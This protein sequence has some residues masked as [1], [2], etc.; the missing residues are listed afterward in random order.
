VDEKLDMS[1]QC[2]LTTQIA[3][4]TLGCIKRSVVSRSKHLVLPLWSGETPPGVLHPALGFPPQERYT[5]V[6]AGPE[7]GHKNDQKDHL[8]YED[9]LRHLG[10]FS[11]E[12]KRLWGVIIEAFQY[13]KGAYKNRGDRL[14]S[15]ASCNRTM[16]NGFKLKGGRYRLDRRKK[17]FTMRVVKHWTRLPR[18]VVCVP[19]LQTFRMRLDGALG[20]MIWLKMSLS[21]MRAL[22]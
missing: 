1:H 5:S 9:K 6:G 15:R 13:L 12:N 8:S 20:N 11:M 18:E 22:D 17:F 7:G 14:F 16:G 19:S 10:L 2:V 3:N 4:C 21:I